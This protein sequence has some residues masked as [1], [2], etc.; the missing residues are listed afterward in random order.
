[1][2]ISKEQLFLKALYSFQEDLVNSKKFNSKD[3]TYLKLLNLIK[4]IE[5]DISLNVGAII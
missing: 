5:E 2:S 4:N 1:M 3:E